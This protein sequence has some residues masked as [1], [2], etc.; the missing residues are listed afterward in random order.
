[1]NDKILGSFCQL[2]GPTAESARK[3]KE[4][5]SAHEEN[6]RLKACIDELR[7]KLRE[8]KTKFMEKGMKDVSDWPSCQGNAPVLGTEDFRPEG[9]IGDPGECQWSE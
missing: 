6:T 2:S 4:L 9:S 3:Q 5:G 8:I 1:M 7:M